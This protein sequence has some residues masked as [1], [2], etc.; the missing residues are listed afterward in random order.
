M[1]PLDHVQS[2]ATYYAFVNPWFFDPT[3]KDRSRLDNLVVAGQIYGAHT[4][5]SASFG[6]RFLLILVQ[7]PATRLFP[8]DLRLST[9]I[10]LTPWT[11][12]PPSALRA[13][14]DTVTEPRLLWGSQH[15][16]EEYLQSIL[17]IQGYTPP[18]P[19][20]FYPY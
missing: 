12:V 11:L 7:D 18:R 6:D 4:F 3:D 17:P 14:W 1:D 15:S 10:R 5:L 16:F 20:R 2:F 19:V 9:Q 13:F 8:P